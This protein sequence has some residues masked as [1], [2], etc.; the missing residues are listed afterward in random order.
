[1][2]VNRT[3]T[4]I[5]LVVFPFLICF[6]IHV[7]LIAI[8]T[9]GTSPELLQEQ[10]IP[11]AQYMIQN[12]QPLPDYIT[13]IEPQTNVISDNNRICVGIN[14]KLVGPFTGFW[15]QIYVNEALLSYDNIDVSSVGLMG[16]SD[17]SLSTTEYC[18]TLTGSIG[19]QIIEIRAKNYY[20][21]NRF[22]YRFAVE[23]INE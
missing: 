8:S 16:F 4:L 13:Y 2:K 19:L 9:N 5:L 12:P 20:V 14:N 17:E 18:F 7:I 11:T 1:L 15:S 21:D 3:L 6:V 10:Y 22:D 23:Y